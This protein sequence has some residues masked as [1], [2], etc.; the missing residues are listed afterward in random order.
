MSGQKSGSRASQP[1]PRTVA[2]TTGLPW[3]ISSGKRD[4]QLLNAAKKGLL[5][6]GVHRPAEHAQGHEQI[7]A[8]GD[9]LRHSQLSDQGL[10]EEEHAWFMHFHLP[11]FAGAA[12]SVD[13]ALKRGADINAADYNGNTALHYACEEGYVELV[14][15][16]LSL[17]DVSI[18]VASMMD[19]TPLHCAASKGRTEAIRL[20]AEKGCDMNLTAR[21]GNTALH[22]AAMGG[23]LAAVQLLVE[24]GCSTVSQNHLG[25]TAADLASLFENGE[26]ER[27]VTH[28]LAYQIEM[29]TST[30]VT[31]GHFALEIRLLR[32]GQVQSLD[33]LGNSDPY[34]SFFL[35]NPPG[36]VRSKTIE[37]SREPE[38]NQILLMRINL[39]PQLLR[40]EIWDDDFGVS[41]D[42]FIGKG[43]IT[44]KDLVSSTM[45]YLDSGAGEKPDHDDPN[46]PRSTVDLE[47]TAKRKT[48]GIVTLGLKILRIPDHLV[49]R[50]TT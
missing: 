5:Y 37:D 30:K 22:L 3:H 23:H 42:D 4:R 31:R 13:E 38:W 21:D 41:D 35:S 27:I 6:S 9:K 19:W 48:T 20:L 28:L 44:L 39:A 16:L 47:M 33:V 29:P 2:F 1:P 36:F 24:L 45:C 11:G 49:A 50:L 15:Y 26:S 46:Y 17:E 43:A 18:D 12:A 8:S 10:H 14:Q 34:C 32:G 7:R 40:V 25:Q